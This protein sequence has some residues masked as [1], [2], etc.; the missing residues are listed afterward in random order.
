MVFLLLVGY[1]Y[2]RLARL[3]RNRKTRRRGEMKA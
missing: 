1:L 3:I 2:L